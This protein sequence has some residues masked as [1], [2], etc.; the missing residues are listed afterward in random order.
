[1]VMN[2]EEVFLGHCP[3]FRFEELRMITG[4]FGT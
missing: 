3:G 1:M 2:E 4:T